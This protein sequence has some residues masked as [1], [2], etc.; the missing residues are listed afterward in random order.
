MAGVGE[1]SSLSCLI[2]LCDFR[3]VPIL[4]DLSFTLRSSSVKHGSWDVGDCEFTKA[5]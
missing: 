5:I 4:S 2:L 3:E 1:G